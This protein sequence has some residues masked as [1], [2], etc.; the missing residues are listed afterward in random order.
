MSQLVALDVFSGIGGITHALRGIAHTVAYCERNQHACAILTANMGR[1]ALPS[2][3]ICD[4]VRAL[5]R[6]W[7]RQ[8]GVAPKVDLVT[9]GF[10]CTGMSIA[11]RRDGFGNAETALFYE[12]LRVID[13]TRPGAVFLENSAHVVA[14]GQGALGEILRQLTTRGYE[15]RYT[16][17]CAHRLGAPHRRPRWYCLAVR[18]SIVGR[19]VRVA[20]A[21]MPYDWARREPGERMVAA[22][23]PTHKARL[24]RLGSSVVPDVARRAFLHLAHG[25]F[26]STPADFGARELRIAPVGA[27]TTSSSFAELP[28][29]GVAR[30]SGIASMLAIAFDLSR[31]LDLVFDPALH[32][33]RAPASPLLGEL[34]TSALRRTY[35]GTPTPRDAENANNRLTL[36]GARIL[37]TQVR[38]ERKTSPRTPYLSPT[39]CEWL[40]GFPVGWTRHDPP[41]GAATP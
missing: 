21:P 8:H 15:V 34:A 7:L 3:P 30:K 26:S 29:H 12:L 32:R 6:A 25:G 39:F 36:R 24:Q 2:A 37:V 41:R 22:R 31:P 17:V 19:S 4:D 5:S 33:T 27:R 14:L 28:L 10:P 20:G 16:V 1:G 23:A 18:P 35:W 9:A 11:G 40:M 38:F 13:E